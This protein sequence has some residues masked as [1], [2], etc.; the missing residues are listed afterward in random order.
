VKA[1]AATLVVSSALAAAAAAGAGT[2]AGVAGCR[3]RVALPLASVLHGERGDVYDVAAVSARDAWVGGWDGVRVSTDAVRATPLLAHWN[4]RRWRVTPVPVRWGIAAR[5]VALAA[6]DVWAV[7]DNR[8]GTLLLHWNGRAWNRAALPPGA[9]AYETSL[10]RGSRGRLWLVGRR[11]YV[12]GRSAWRLQRQFG[13]KPS[14]TRLVFSRWTD[15]V[16]KVVPSAQPGES[17]PR[18]ERWNGRRWVST[19]IAASR[20]TEL[21]VPL[22]FSPRDT[23]LGATDGD[24]ALL[25]R[26]NGRTWRRVGG[27]LPRRAVTATALAPSRADLW[28]AG[29]LANASRTASPPYLRHRLGG[30]WTTVAPPTREDADDVTLYGVGGEIWARTD[31]RDDVYRLVC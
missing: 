30:R 18:V 6:N 10:A 27:S 8:D 13:E 28:L 3:W 12:R 5:V 1:A 4:G 22:A 14:N 2:N 16:W 7:V 26:W 11:V 15:A 17:P 9:A 31:L 19:P 20:F 23:W 24:N 21:G 29:S 25:F